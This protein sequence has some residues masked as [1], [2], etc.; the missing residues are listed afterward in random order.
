MQQHLS[1]LQ[2][3]LY[4]LLNNDALLNT[5]IKGIYDAAPENPVFPYITLSDT[6]IEDAS[7]RDI[8]ISDI[9]FELNIWSNYRGRSELYDISETLDA[10]I[11]SQ[12]IR[13]SGA[14][15]LIVI[16]KQQQRFL[17]LDKQRIVQ[18]N[19]QYRAIMQGGV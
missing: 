8:I 7:V 12:H 19:I 18:S 4:A 3:A 5:K 16:Q 13:D 6:Y 2:S 9:R 11:T 1:T 17:Q 14:D 10:L 15:T